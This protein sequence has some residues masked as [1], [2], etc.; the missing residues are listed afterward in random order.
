MTP[1]KWSRMFWNDLA[2]RVASTEIAA[3]LSTSLLMGATGIDWHNGQAVWIL[4]G[5]PPAVSLLKGLAANLGSP[6]S[7]PSLLPA[8]PAPPVAPFLDEVGDVDP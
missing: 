7:G 8:P 5:A 4:L 1:T 3:L 6:S 2:E